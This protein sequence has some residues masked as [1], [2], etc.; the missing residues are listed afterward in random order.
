[1]LPAYCQKVYLSPK[2]LAH[3]INL[4]RNELLAILKCIARMF[5]RCYE[6]KIAVMS[7]SM[8]HLHFTLV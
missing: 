3:I 5:A 8:S 1:M 2:I 6:Q 7:E 4:R